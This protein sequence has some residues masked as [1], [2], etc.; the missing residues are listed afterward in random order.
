VLNIFFNP[1]NQPWYYYA[2]YSVIFTISLI[3][4]DAIV[5]ITIRKMPERFFQKDKR[6]YRLSKGEKKFYDLIGVKKWKEKVPELG[7]F[8]SFHKDH[9]ADPF[10]NDYIERFILEARYGISIHLW[11]VPLGFLVIFLDYQMFSGTSSL[12]LTMAIPLAC[13]NAILVVAPAFILKYNLPKLLKIRDHNLRLRE[14][15]NEKSPS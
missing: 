6:A 10:N 3:I 15:A 12:Y 9:V 1:S 11:S 8:T 2:I 13:I 14:K 4:I 5:A 7:G